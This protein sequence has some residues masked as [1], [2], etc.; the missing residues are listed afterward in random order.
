[1]ADE[2]RVP[3]AFSA[4]QAISLP[5]LI[6]TALNT[7]RRDMTKALIIAGAL[8]ASTLAGLPDASAKNMNLGLTIAGANGF[9]QISGPGPNHKPKHGGKSQGYGYQGHKPYQN[10]YGQGYGYQNPYRG[11]R[12]LRRG[13]AQG[14]CMYP[15]Q[16]RRMLR[17]QGWHG[18]RV[19]KLTP[20]I[21]IIHTNRNGMR[22][23]L[24]LNRCT[25]EMIRVK[26]LGGFGGYG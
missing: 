18:F 14:Y 13:R 24:K 8:V 2:W 1:M 25:G 7:G 9:I 10:G 5:E 23:R 22:Y 15:N 16:I 6:G 17:Y 11:Y 20:S 19:R 21:A 26:P 12:N 4:P 3:T